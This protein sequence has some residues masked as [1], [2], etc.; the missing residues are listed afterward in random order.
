MDNCDFCK[1]ANASPDHIRSCRILQ[2]CPSSTD[3]MLSLVKI[4]LERIDHLEDQLLQKPSKPHHLINQLNDSEPPPCS[5]EHYYTSKEIT[6]TQL[7]RCLCNHTQA[8]VF[9]SEPITEI[10]ASWFNSPT[11]PIKAFESKPNKIY[12]YENKWIL[13]NAY[14]LKKFMNNLNKKLMECLNKNWEQK[15][16]NE[17][18]A[19]LYCDCMMTICD[20]KPQRQTFLKKSLYTILVSEN[21]PPKTPYMS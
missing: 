3:P 16:D 6:Q 18:H 2:Q 20:N 19:Q 17:K 4:L 11:L 13:L 1:K 9:E 14:H 5:F 8:F 21:T 7:N 10:L 12:I 15:M